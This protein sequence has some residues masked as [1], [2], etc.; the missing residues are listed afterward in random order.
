M[1]PN[2]F[3]GASLDTGKVHSCGCWGDWQEG[4]YSIMSFMDFGEV[5]EEGMSELQLEEANI[6][7]HRI[8][9]ESSIYG[10]CIPCLTLPLSLRWRKHDKF[11]KTQVEM[12]GREWD[13]PWSCRCVCSV[14]T[15]DRHQDHFK[16]ND[17]CLKNILVTENPL[18]ALRGGQMSR[19]AG[20]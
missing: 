19:A 5:L 9:G 2:C 7:G 12:N 4:K 6:T 15:V 18:E 20:R 13:C 3:P 14:W 10:S 17:L 16:Q 8:D 11:D 1:A